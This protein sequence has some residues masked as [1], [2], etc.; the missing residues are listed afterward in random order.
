MQGSSETVTLTIPL[1]AGADNEIVISALHPVKSIYV[2]PP[3][4]TYYPCT[5]AE[6][7]GQANLTTCGAEFCQPVG[8]KIGNLSPNSSASFS[9]TARGIQPGE[10]SRKYVEIDYINNDISTAS[11]NSRNITVAVN[12]A[13]PVRL[14]VPLTGRNSELFGPG[15][16]WWDSSSLGLLLD[17]WQDGENR[18]AVGNVNG[19][20]GLVAH[21]AEFVGMKLYD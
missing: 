7:Y 14:T 9:M 20:K 17:G 3:P 1:S 21:G 4:G 5:Y 2:R 19:Y 6:I 12:D 16:G 18:V 10:K 13:R 11:S 15:L 8:S